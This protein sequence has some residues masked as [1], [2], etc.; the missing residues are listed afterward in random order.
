M[1][2]LVLNQSFQAI[3]LCDPRRALVLVML[4]KA[5]LISDVANLRLRSVSQDFSFPS[6]IRLRRYVHVPYQKVA[7]TRHNVYK[8]D[9]NKCVYCNSTQHLTLDHVIPKAKGGKTAWNNLVTA[10]R[11]CNA[12][13]GD[14][15]PEEAGLELQRDPFRP[16]FIMFL[17]HYGGQ[18]QDDWKPYLLAS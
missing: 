17:S 10:C 4:E 3:S 18:I 15:T 8:R 16:S 12:Q 14:M 1:Q 11:K 6:I 9:G 13:K 7:L 5:E 2:V